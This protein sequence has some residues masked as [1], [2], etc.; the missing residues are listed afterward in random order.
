MKAAK[1]FYIGLVVAIINTVQFFLT[2]SPV[3]ITGIAV[4]L[5]FVAFGWKIGWTKYRGFTVLL[6]HIAIT[7]GSL[8]SAYAIYQIPFLKTPPAFLEVLDMPL[9][10]GIFTIFGGYCMITH[11]YC[12]CVINSHEGHHCMKE[13]LKK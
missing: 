9:F 10:W 8:L 1:T 5:F 3:R 12:S 2:S 4:G 6:G 13:Q 7:V 11:G